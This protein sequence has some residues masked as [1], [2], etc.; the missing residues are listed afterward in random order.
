MNWDHWVGSRSPGEWNGVEKGAVRNFAEAIG[1]PQPLYL[2]EEGAKHLRYGRWMAPPT[3]PITFRYGSIPGLQLPKSGLIHGSQ[4]FQYERP[5]WIGE[6][7]FCYLTLKDVFEKEGKSG[8][9]TF[10]TFERIGEDQKGDR[11]FTAESTLIV[12]EA[13]RRELSA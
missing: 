12:T 6:E 2:C 5:L 11:V 7:I 1:D 13:V 3:F 9:L 4:R 8:R 10:L